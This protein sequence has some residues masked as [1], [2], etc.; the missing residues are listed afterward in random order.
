LVENPSYYGQMWIHDYSKSER[1]FAKEAIIARQSTKPASETTKYV[2]RK[3]ETA[4][5]SAYQLWQDKG[6]FI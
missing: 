5:M 4:A 1:I 3:N 6:I 2:L